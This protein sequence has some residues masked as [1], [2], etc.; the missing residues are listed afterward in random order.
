MSYSDVL[1]VVF[2]ILKIMIMEEE[3]GEL[4]GIDT[5]GGSS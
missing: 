5:L 1:F 3:G 4:Q 2:C